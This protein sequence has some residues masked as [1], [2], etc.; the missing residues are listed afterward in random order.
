MDCIM[1]KQVLESLI[2]KSDRIST[3]WAILGKG[4]IS[5]LIYSLM[6]EEGYLDNL[7][8]GFIE[9]YTSSENKNPLKVTSFQGDDITEYFQKEILSINKKCDIYPSIGYSEMNRNRKRI[10][11]LIEE[12]SPNF[13]IRSFISSKAYIG[14]NSRI[15]YGCLVLPKSIIEPDVS[16]GK[17]TVAWFGAQV[18]HHSDIEEFNW[19][20]A[21]SVIGAKCK[22]GPR[23]FLG[24]GSIIP[25]GANIS[26]GTLIM[27]GSTAPTS[28]KGNQVITRLP[29][30]SNPH[31][32]ESDEFI[33]F[34]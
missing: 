33:R 12:I 29:Q 21:G 3:K 5:G 4:G 11:T 27:A 10:F 25:S 30:S 8:I 28:T 17:G 15:D 18:C 24:I 9:I 6:I 13:K 31:M 26:E 34:L 16:L 22:V 32:L 23:S 2:K 19:I 1:G 7:F 20:A 14:N